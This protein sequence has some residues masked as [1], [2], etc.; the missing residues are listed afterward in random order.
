MAGLVLPRQL[1]AS[2]TWVRPRPR[3]SSTGALVVSLTTANYQTE[4]ERS[5]IFTVPRHTPA[6]PDVHAS[7][8]TSEPPFNTIG[9][10]GFSIESKSTS[11]VHQTGCVLMINDTHAWHNLPDRGQHVMWELYKKLTEYR[12]RDVR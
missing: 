10:I 12:K 6:S 7:L 9:H 1:S 11:H 5:R 3:H 4:K 8:L 2:V